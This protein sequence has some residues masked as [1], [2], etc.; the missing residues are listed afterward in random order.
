MGSAVH[1]TCSDGILFISAAAAA[2]G[3]TLCLGFLDSLLGCLHLDGVHIK[4]WMPRALFQGVPLP[5]LLFLLFPLWSLLLSRALES[6][7]NIVSGSSM[8]RKVRPSL[9]GSNCLTA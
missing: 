2:L 9:T 3:G 5:A 8:S 7:I 4:V 6:N 1:C